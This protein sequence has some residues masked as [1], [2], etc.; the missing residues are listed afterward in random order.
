M[1]PVL[2]NFFDIEVHSFG[3]MVC[4]AWS[5]GRYV[6]RRHALAA[7]LDDSMIGS[8]WFWG[9]IA[10]LV[11]A[12]LP[13]LV[14]S[15]SVE[16]STAVHVIEQ[17]QRSELSSVCALLSAGVVAAGI[18][19]A[20]RKSI[21]RYADTSVSGVFA[22]LAVCRLGCFLNGCCFGLA[23]EYS[24]GCVFDAHSPAGIYAASIGANRL[25]P[26]QLILAAGNCGLS[27]FA[28][29]FEGLTCRH[30][31]KCLVMSLLYVGL[32]CSVS[33]LRVS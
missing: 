7:G 26:T 33:F 19:L 3:V 25:L 11:G 2:V 30:G 15:A 5:V 10:G 13:D 8:C 9:L 21:W 27:V 28:F 20:H 18:L 32:R 17:F 14:S 29:K 16:T 1:Y 23:T 24:W 31:M 12:R 22:F 6:S 4:C